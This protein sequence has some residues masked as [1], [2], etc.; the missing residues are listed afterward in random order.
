[1]THR[2][3]FSAVLL[4][5]FAAQAQD[6]FTPLEQDGIHDP[7]SPATPLLQPPQ[8]AL[9]H[10]PEDANGNPDWMGALEDGDIAPRMGVSAT[11][12]MRAID[13]DIVMDNTAS[14]PPV[15][16]RHK[17][18]TQW[19]TCSNCHTQIFLP[20]VNANF[21]TMASIMKGEHCGVCHGKVA[22]SQLYC[23]RCHNQPNNR[24]GLR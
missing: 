18:H 17:T 7:Q 15:R 10:L 23:E 5:C 19:L 9:Q 1:M 14:M 3:L 12:T 20:Q 21:V 13:L 8:Q 2:I 24:A 4:T 11:E 22:F 6:G 16:F